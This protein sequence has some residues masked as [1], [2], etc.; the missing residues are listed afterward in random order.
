MV[1]IFYN[2]CVINIY[3]VMMHLS[4]TL[5]V[6]LSIGILNKHKLLTNCITEH[7]MWKL[8]KVNQAKTKC[9]CNNNVTFS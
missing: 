6:S 1:S 5:I 8:T 3:V 4:K 9:T 7:K 2:H